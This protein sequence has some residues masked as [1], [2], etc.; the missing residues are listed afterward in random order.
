MQMNW[1]PVYV[2]DLILKPADELS[3]IQGLQ[4]M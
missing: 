3:L 4:E 1:A 2:S